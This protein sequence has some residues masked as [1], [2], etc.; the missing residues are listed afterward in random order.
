MIFLVPVFVAA[1]TGVLFCILF[2]RSAIVGW[3]VVTRGAQA[4]ALQPEWC[5]QHDGICTLPPSAGSDKTATA[6]KT[7]GV[8]RQ[9]QVQQANMIYEADVAGAQRW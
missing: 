7:P 5:L 2:S 3:I 9:Q 1:A 4:S 6:Y 8:P